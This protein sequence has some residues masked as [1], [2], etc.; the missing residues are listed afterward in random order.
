[1]T[2]LSQRGNDSEAVKKLKFDISI[3]MKKLAQYK[4]AEKGAKDIVT[5][6]ENMKQKYFKVLKDNESQ[7]ETI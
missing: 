5:E 7:K 1:L 3:I 2:N 6:Y 4:S